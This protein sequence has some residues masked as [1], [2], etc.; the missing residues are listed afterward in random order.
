MLCKAKNSVVVEY[1]LRDIKKPISVAEATLTRVLPEPLQGQLPTI[2]EL[3]AEL[4]VSPN[5]AE[6]EEE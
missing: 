6:D 2:E 3:E 5:L 1:A 4:Q